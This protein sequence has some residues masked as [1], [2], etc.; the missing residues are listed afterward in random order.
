MDE[1]MSRTEEQKFKWDEQRIG[2]VFS[3]S[4]RRPEGLIEMAQ[5]MNNS[6]CRFED[7]NVTP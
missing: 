1:S 6:S 4:C 2:E 7:E 3:S 5:T